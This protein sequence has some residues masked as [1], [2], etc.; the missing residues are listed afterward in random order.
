MSLCPVQKRI[1][2]WDWQQ[3]SLS[4]TLVS[5][6]RS[7]L[8]ILLPLLVFILGCGAPTDGDGKSGA[9]QSIAGSDVKDEKHHSKIK[10]LERIES[11]AAKAFNDGDYPAAR[12]FIARAMGIGD[13]LKK[14]LARARMLLL[15]GDIERVL[16][17][18]VEARRHYTDA[19]AIF[20]VHKNDEGEFKTS[21]AFSKLEA[22]RGDHAAS[23]RQMGQAQV[24]LPQ[25]KDRK[26]EGAYY[27]QLGRLAARQVKPADA[28]AAFEKA[29]KIFEAIKDKQSAGDVFML[30]ASEEDA[31][32]NGRQ[33]RLR[34]ERAERLFK[35]IGY[36]EGQVRALHRIAALTERDKNYFKAK[37]QLE[38]VLLLYEK[39]DNKSAATS[40]R[41]HMDSLPLP[42][43]KKKKKK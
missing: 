23:A 41:R 35:D 28:K 11:S 24:L 15:L 9:G 8:K 12:N 1:C 18:E 13:K 5:V 27:V 26:L 10:E 3:A 20:H 42:S 30:L 16:G 4:E 17:N 33:S 19:M 37:K 32:G 25:I 38:Q 43:K 29:A 34:L 39:L 40:V 31:M 21:I 6:L 7:K 2:L 36:L 22:G 14:E